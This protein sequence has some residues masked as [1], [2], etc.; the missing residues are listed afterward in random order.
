MEAPTPVFSLPDALPVARTASERRRLI[1]SLA[2]PVILTFSLESIVALCDTLMVGQLGPVAVAGVGVGVQVLF[3]VEVVMF[4]VGTGTL[5]VV[6]RQFGAREVVEAEKTL[7]Q[8][9]VCVLALVLLAATPVFLRAPEVVGAFGVDDAVRHEGSRYVRVVLGA[10]PPGAVLFV[11]FSA[12]RGAGDMRTPLLVGVVV[13]LAN[14][15]G[16]YVFI[17]GKLGFPALGVPGSALGTALAFWVGTALALWL[18]ARGRL[19]IRL[20]TRGWKPELDAIRR[21]L[22]VGGPSAVEQALMQLGFFL[23]LTFAA[24]YGTAAVAAYFVGVR[25]LG[26][27]F[28]PGFG[29]GA[30]AASLVGQNLGAGRPDEAERYAWEAN[31][32]AV[33]LMTAGGVLIYAAAR[34]VARLFVDEPE[35]VEAT[36]GFIHV[37]AACQPLMAVDFTL[38]GALRGAG[39]TR[40]PLVAVLVGFYLCRLGM[41]YVVTF[42]VEASLPWLW[43]ALFGDYSA[44]CALKAWRFRSNSWKEVRV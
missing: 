40:F 6:A 23:Y 35:V 24:R 37:L 3:A 9:I 36:V 4:A 32:L 10:V 19:R 2:W 25:I 38:G 22:R 31:R 13:N 34:P 33:L 1:W 30:A 20:R 29:F 8:S 7:Q 17:F 44:R 42:W 18:L 16:N 28:L 27:S 15:L 26:L 11:V 21:L 5:A 43:R 41:A 14:V 12:L 39:D